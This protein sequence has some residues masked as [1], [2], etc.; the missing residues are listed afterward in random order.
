[1]CAAHLVHNFKETDNEVKFNYRNRTMASIDLHA[2][3][4]GGG[5]HS[6][7]FFANEEGLWRR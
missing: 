4:G 2:M 3:W 6:A 5:G 7:L 1:M